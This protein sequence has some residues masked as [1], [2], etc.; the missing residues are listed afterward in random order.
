MYQVLYRKWR[1]QT[2][3]DVY[4][5]SLITTA[6]K[7][8]MRTGR[9]AHAYLFTGSRGTG[10]TT[11]AKI[12]AK[13]VNCLDPQ[14]G[15]PCN[16]CEV[17]RGIDDGTILDVVEIDAASNNGVDNI[18]DLREE[19]NFTPAIAKY[20]V[21]IID[22]VHMLSAGAFNALLKTLEEPPAHVIFVLAT[23]EVHKLPA[24]ILSRCQRFDFG[25]IAP[26]DIV[27]RIQYIAGQEG[28][29]ITD[30]AALLVSR[31]ADGGM[32]DALSLLDQC[33]SRS[34]DITA[35][36]V[37]DA[38]GMA[39]D[40]CLFEFS[41][42]VRAS[43]GGAALRLIGQLHEA[44]RD[45]ERLCAELIEFYRNLMIVKSVP[46]PSGLIVASAAELDRLRE[47]AAA[48]E[49]PVVLHCMDVLQDALERLRS[50]VSRRIEMEMAMLRLCSPEL[51]AG[52][53]ALLRRVKAL[54]TALKTG[55]ISATPSAA[56]YAAEPSS[57]AAAKNSFQA[58]ATGEKSPLPAS[59]ASEDEFI[60]P[61]ELPPPIHDSRVTD[62]KAFSP[63]SE[64]SASAETAFGRWNDVLEALSVSCPPLCGVLQGSSA[65]LK[66]DFVVIESE[67]ELFKSL[68]ARDGNK[69]IL[70][71]A[72]R[73]VTGQTYRIGF[74]KQ[75]AFSGSR[76]SESPASGSGGDDPLAAFIQ[77]SRNLG[78]DMNIK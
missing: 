52:N 66:G 6:L 29:T 17:C 28:F 36:T 74:K 69:A 64:Q 44:S 35:D 77:N 5:Q 23:T 57:P 65:S 78:V 38:A 58:E 61:P 43:D 19:I 3:S 4:G 54:E 20:R 50:G 41:A 39:G 60:P 18:R 47:E 59:A 48:Y 9:F 70:V 1:P 24:T 49:L 45:M 10:K 31:L 62:A 14:D 12:L 30:E 55:R 56:A 75:S 26:E 25:R 7:N 53:A 22:E 13:A 68:V 46:D 33:V 34:H 67:N 73:G 40:D 63:A 42:A 16:Q 76:S 37:T 71:D 72:I 11:C 27:A 51:D 21:Y 8:E 2:F 15:D 32:R